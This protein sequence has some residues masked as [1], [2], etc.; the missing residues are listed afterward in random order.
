MISVVGNNKPG[1]VTTSV[2]DLVVPATGLAINIQRNYDSLN[3]GTSGDFGYGWSLGTSV[4]LTVDP[5]GD[6]TLTLGGQ[7][8]TFYLTPQFEGFLPFYS[9]AFTPEPGFH[10]TLTDAAQG[11][12]ISLTIL[13]PTAPC[14]PALVE[15]STI[16]Q[17]MF[18]PIHRERRTP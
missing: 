5:R 6:V 4:N 3:A 11:A 1:R 17:G 15:G 2:T 18:T 9:V 8:R 12:L 16:R 14:G 10:G 13:F 7:R